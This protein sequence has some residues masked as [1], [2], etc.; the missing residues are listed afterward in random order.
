[1][2]H[3]RLVAFQSIA[4]GCGFAGFAI[5]CV[6][7]GVSFEPLLA[8]RTGGILMTLMTVILLYKARE[9]LV[10]DYRRS[11]MWIMLDRANRPPEAYAR[12]AAPTVL[13]DAYL[14]FAQYAAAIAIV[15]WV[16][17]LAISL[18]GIGSNRA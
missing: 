8:A 14:W 6:V 17:A 12:W 1:M 7:A 16:V 15:F 2:E 9:A 5:F 3:L 13:R 18:A 10:R 4:R 11:E